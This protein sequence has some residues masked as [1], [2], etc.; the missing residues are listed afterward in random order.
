MAEDAERS[1]QAAEEG[2]EEGE[3]E[4]EKGRKRRGRPPK[5][6]QVGGRKRGRPKTL[7]EVE[8]IVEERREEAGGGREFLIQWRGYKERTWEPERSAQCQ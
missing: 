7:Y 3:V 5:G 8:R 1:T 2:E 6:A 4:E